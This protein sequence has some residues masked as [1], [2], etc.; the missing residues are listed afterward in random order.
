MAT[1]PRDLKKS[2]KEKLEKVETGFGLELVQGKT[3]ER[4]GDIKELGVSVMSYRLSRQH[5]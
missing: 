3:F 2:L 4:V 1:Y 5:L